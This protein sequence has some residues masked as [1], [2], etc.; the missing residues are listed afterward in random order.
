MHEEQDKSREAV[1][2]T[3]GAQAGFAARFGLDRCVRFGRSLSRDEK[4]V[5]SI[6]YALLCAFIALGLV[7]ALGDFGR[8]VGSGWTR[9]EGAIT[10]VLNMQSGPE[11][12]DP[13]QQRPD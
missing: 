12:G 3:F 5:S 11:A 13:E 10:E 1:R 7:G 4:G 6:E 9:V 2:R 8:A